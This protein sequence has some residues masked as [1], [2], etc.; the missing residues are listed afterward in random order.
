MINW[1][2]QNPVVYTIF[3]LESSLSDSALNTWSGLRL[4]KHMIDMDYNYWIDKHAQGK[5]LSYKQR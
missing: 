5:S 4:I 1:I 2:L 3:P